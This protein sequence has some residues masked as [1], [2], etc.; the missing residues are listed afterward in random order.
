MHKTGV[1]ME[2]LMGATVAALTIYNMHKAVS[3]H[4][5]WIGDTV[6]VGK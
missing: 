4:N 5:L 3:H 1:Q 2:T 6:L